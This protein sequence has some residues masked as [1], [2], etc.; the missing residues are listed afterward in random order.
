[1][2]IVYLFFVFRIEYYLA[3][4][5]FTI[6]LVEKLY[7]EFLWKKLYW[8]F[9]QILQGILSYF[10]LLGVLLQVQQFCCRKIIFINN[11]SF[12][13]FILNL[14]TYFLIIKLIWNFLFKKI[15]YLK[16]FP[17]RNNKIQVKNITWI[18]FY[19]SIVFCMRKSIIEI[20]DLSFNW[21]YL[22]LNLAE[23]MIS[24]EFFP[25]FVR[26]SASF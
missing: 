17:W 13:S 4:F 22:K 25:T 11:C 5:T 18:K 15:T 6:Y 26:F 20:K 14:S 24:A 23:L 9:L 10:L 3:L 2:E 8:P 7:F 1:M 16:H 19:E 12:E 21:N